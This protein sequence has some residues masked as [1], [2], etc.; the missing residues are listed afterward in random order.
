ME[1]GGH[2]W[3]YKIP[4]VVVALCY[5]NELYLAKGPAINL[6]QLFTEVKV[7]LFSDIFK[8]MYKLVYLTLSTLR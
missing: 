4:T 3:N 7:V 2:N 6:L 5:V 8:N 1:T